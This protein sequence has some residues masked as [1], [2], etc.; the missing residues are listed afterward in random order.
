MAM[1]EEMV[2]AMVLSI[3]G[4]YKIRYH[5]EGPEGPELEIDFA[6][7]FRRISMCSGLEEALGVTLPKDLESEEARAFL[8]ALCAEHGVECAPPQTT[9][10]LLDKLVG[11]FLESQCLNPTFICDH[12]QI[13]SPLAK[14]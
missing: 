12:P 6:P 5:P 1:T 11:E 3:C 4:Q 9:A 8:A 10:R 2:S 7:P 14:W 13:M